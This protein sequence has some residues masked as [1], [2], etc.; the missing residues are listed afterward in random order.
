M[1]EVRVQVFLH[2]RPGWEWPFAE[3]P[4]HWIAIG[5]HRDLTQAFKIALRNAVE[6]LSLKAGLSRLDAYSLASLAA[7]FRITQVVDI[8]QGVHAMIPKNIFASPLREIIKIV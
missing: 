7:S 1:R 8:N 3:T 2:E 5:A 4:T 6:F